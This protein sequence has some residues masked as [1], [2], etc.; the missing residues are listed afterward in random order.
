MDRTGKVGRVYA[1]LRRIQIE[2]AEALPSTGERADAKV[3]VGD[4]REHG[5]AIADTSV[6][7]ILRPALC[8][9]IRAGVRRPRRFAARVLIDGGSL[10]TYFGNRTLPDVMQLMTPH[11]RYHWLCAVTLTGGKQ[12]LPGKSVGV[13]S[14]LSHCCRS[15]RACVEPTRLSPTSSNLSAATRSPATVGRRAK[16]KRAISSN[17]CR[18][19]VR[20]SSIRFSAAAP[21]AWRHLKP[22][23]GSWIGDRPRD[24]A[25][26][27]GAD[28]A[29]ERSVMN[30]HERRAASAQAYDQAIRRGSGTTPRK[31]DMIQMRKQR[32]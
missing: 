29:R 28:D 15:P 10:I 30:R 1:E 20:S 6:D 11:L 14:G 22:D 16:S 27:R 9:R 2:E 24:L 3:I 31:P 32:R 7:L 13:Q 18:A 17:I 12:T 26:G 8:A 21:R 25:Q 5:R 4:F 23:A 19:K